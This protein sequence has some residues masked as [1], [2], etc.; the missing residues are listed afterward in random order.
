MTAA[1]L[2]SD[3]PKPARRL[4]A[5]LLLAFLASVLVFGVALP[6]WETYVAARKDAAEL[7]AT[8]VPVRAAARDRTALEAELARLKAR[9]P[10]VGLLSGASDALAAAELQNR[11]KSAAERSAGEFRSVQILPPRDEGPFRRITVRAE[12]KV[13]LGE[14]VHITH[15]LE[16]GS[17]LLFLDNVELR[18]EPGSRSAR[19]TESSEEDPLLY[20]AFDVSGYMRKAAGAGA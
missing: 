16:S 20:V 3:L 7:E 8:L 13:R 12:M 9:R 1:P 6:A 5:L 17:P 19:I 11:L 15:Q 14:L 2:V 4:I 10:A 18:V